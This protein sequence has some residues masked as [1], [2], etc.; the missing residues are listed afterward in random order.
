[1]LSEQNIIINCSV[2]RLLILCFSYV[3]SKKKN[4]S[5]FYVLSDVTPCNEQRVR[6]FRD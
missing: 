2:Q 3:C 1:M 6:P 5:P 4:I